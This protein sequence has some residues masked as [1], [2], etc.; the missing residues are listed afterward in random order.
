MVEFN[1]RLNSRRIRANESNLR[2]GNQ[3]WPRNFK[4]GISRGGHLAV[5]FRRVSYCT[6]GFFVAKPTKQFHS[7]CVVFLAWTYTSHMHLGYRVVTNHAAM[8]ICGDCT[9]WL[10][11]IQRYNNSPSMHNRQ[12]GRHSHSVTQWSK[13]Y[14]VPHFKFL[15]PDRF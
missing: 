13:R 14:L 1:Q 2:P 7:V 10:R 3:T 9:E 6:I 8:I 15:G 5:T 11:K 12:N 4:G